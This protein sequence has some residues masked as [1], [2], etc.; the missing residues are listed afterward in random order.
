MDSKLVDDEV[1]LVNAC[2]PDKID[3]R[4]FGPFPRRGVRGGPE[5]HFYI[6]SPVHSTGLPVALGDIM[7]YNDA[8]RIQ[9]GSSNRDNVGQHTK[10]FDQIIET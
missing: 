2:V 6:D 1:F 4:Y 3:G 5:M 9:V 8:R 7:L 10:P